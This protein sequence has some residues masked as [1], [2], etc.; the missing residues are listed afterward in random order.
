MVQRT[1]IL[2]LA[3]ILFIGIGSTA[4]GE[5]PYPSRPVICVIPFPGGGATD[6][7]I[8]ALCSVIPQYIGQPF[9]PNGKGGGGGTVGTYE[10]VKSKP[11]GYTV[12]C[13]GN[14]LVMPELYAHFNKAPYTYKDSTAVCQWAGFIPTI[15]VR[16]D[17]PWNTLKE[18]MEDAK[19]K[20]LKFGGPGKTTTNYV[21]ALALARKYNVKLNG[22]P[23]KGDGE[24][25]TA[26]LGGHVDMGMLM[27]ASV[28]AQFDAGT[29]R[30][31]AVGYDTRLPDFSGVPTIKEQGYDVGFD[32][33]F[34]GMYVPPK[35][36][37][38]RIK[39]L[40]EAVK[41]VTEDESFLSMMN[42]FSMPVLY[43]DTETYRKKLIMLQKTL[44]KVFADLGLNP[45]PI[46]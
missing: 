45:T 14:S 15:V 25:V 32:A 24:V 6:I 42:K 41:K 35:T 12:L 9:I 21:L 8:R 29:L 16:K 30:V 10:M 2:G 23:F 36:P 4:Q 27:T 43:A 28:K 31:L 34:M 37:S 26:L 13:A 44:T 22:V 17:A 38:D 5:E 20:I 39:V 3:L 40:S 11:D 46:D 19:T 7:S 33:M 1:V 18:F